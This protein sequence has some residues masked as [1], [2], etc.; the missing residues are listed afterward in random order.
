MYESLF[1][2]A[3][4]LAAAIVSANSREK[5]PP[6]PNG[7]S[8]DPDYAAMPILYHLSFLQISHLL[9]AAKDDL[10]R[11]NAEL[12]RC[13]AGLEKC[14][15][16]LEKC[17]AVKKQQLYLASLQNDQDILQALPPEILGQIFIEVWPEIRLGSKNQH[18]WFHPLVAAYPVGTFRGTA[19][20]INRGQQLSTQGYKC[21]PQKLPVL[22]LHG[23][24]N[25]V[26]SFPATKNFYD[27]LRASDK[28]FI[29]YTVC[30]GGT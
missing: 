26:N 23:T 11:C 5:L 9:Y 3:Y 21:W 2:Y 4:W 30:P 14:N 10:R 7:S 16:E 25:M 6:K 13:N 1:C 28:R 27:I 12:E 29:E 24:E 19:D 17:D 20:M 8:L 15:A 22:I 18:S